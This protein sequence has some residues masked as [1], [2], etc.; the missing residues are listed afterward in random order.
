MAQSD[1]F[2][3]RSRW[4]PRLD[5]LA[6]GLTRRA[7][8]FRHPSKDAEQRFWVGLGRV[9]F[10][11][12]TLLGLEARRI[13]MT[14]ETC[15]AGGDA[16]RDFFLAGLS[17]KRRTIDLTSAFFNRRAE[18]GRFNPIRIPSLRGLAATAPY[19]HRGKFPTLRAMSHHVIVDEFA[20]KA[21]APKVMRALIAY[22]RA[23]EPAPNRRL[24][25]AGRLTRAGSVSAR[26]GQALFT[27][28]WP[29]KRGRSCASCHN[30]ARA[31]T[32]GKAHDVG[33]GGRIDTPSLLGAAL[34]GPF[35]HD[36]R[37][38]RLDQ[39][40]G[41]YARFAGRVLP[42][43]QRGELVAY[44]HEVGAAMGAYEPITLAGDLARVDA[45]VAILAQALKRGEPALAAIVIVTVRRDLGRIR[46][47]FPGPV[48]AQARRRL[49]GWSRALQSVGR[50]KSRPRAARAL[51]KARTAGGKA[52]SALAKVEETSL[53]DPIR[54]RAFLAARRG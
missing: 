38:D 9:V 5:V 43:R 15:H 32:D 49:V 50:A 54:L 4:L 47:R 23:L 51:T 22:L 12:P 6:A 42:P 36:G 16:N 27:K 40:A 10:R 25:P 48:H 19:G 30:P 2:A 1:G 24:G 26:R 3:Q 11:A 28:T 29:G 13:G 45:G 18:D 33:T 20:G 35:M 14:C 52:K 8:E 44:L 41:H 17:G 53:Y 31:F 37:L 7:K 39:A 21:P 34:G 46:D